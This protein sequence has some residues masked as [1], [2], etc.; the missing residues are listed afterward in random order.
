MKR[1]VA[2]VMLV[3]ASIV[4]LSPAAPAQAA[5]SANTAVWVGAPFRG[6][7]AGTGQRPASSL[8]GRHTPVY[9]VP[10]NSYK[11]DWAM[12]FY[13]AAGT[14][15]RLYAAPRNTA[16]NSS[17]T[18]KVLI[19][20]PACGSG[21]IAN[22]GHVVIVGIFDQGVRIGSI[23]YAHVNPAVSTGQTIPRW[24]GYIGTIGKYTKNSCSGRGHGRRSARSRRDGQRLRMGLLPQSPRGSARG[25]PPVSTWDTW[26]VSAAS[27]RV[28]ATSAVPAGSS[29]LAAQNT[30]WPSEDLGGGAKRRQCDA[31]QSMN[32]P[33]LTTS[34]PVSHVPL[35]RRELA[36]RCQDQTNH[37]PVVRA[38]RNRRRIPETGTTDSRRA[39]HERAGRDGWLQR[40]YPRRAGAVGVARNHGN[41]TRRAGRSELRA[42][43][44]N[45]GASR[46][47]GNGATVSQVEC[48]TNAAV[49][50]PATFA[51][52]WCYISRGQ[53]GATGGLSCRRAWRRACVG[54]AAG[55]RRAPD[56]GAAGRL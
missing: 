51:R 3:V 35:V 18:A 45:L 9:T 13:A 39:C 20:K 24:G 22:G 23:A 56:S 40:E 2:F 42:Q 7:L 43:S 27:G 29:L 37:R 17:I 41:A 8:P 52:A 47:D 16:Q 49:A 11:H 48:I 38:Y 34:Y 12:D 31:A 5:G 25:M 14:Q 6:Q 44:T 46:R 54:G 53:P 30:P 28:A 55:D 50:V 1:L 21:I 4:A 33:T 32:M 36:L 10:G 15:V 26:A 19:V